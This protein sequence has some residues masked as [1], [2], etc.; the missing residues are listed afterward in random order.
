MSNKN[1]LLSFFLTLG[2]SQFSIPTNGQVLLPYTPQLSMEQL[3]AQGLKMAEEASQLV[4]FQQHDHALSRAKLAVQL[5]PQKYQPWFIL[6]ALYVMKQDLDLG[7]DALKKSLDLEPKET[8]IKFTLGNAYFQ[9]G[10]YRLAA[11]QLEEG[12][13]IQPNTSSAQFDLGNTYFKLK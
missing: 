12:L 5:A 3:K 1:L 4:R 6:G 13:K 10:K 2:I 9:Q 11:T 7:I 8:T